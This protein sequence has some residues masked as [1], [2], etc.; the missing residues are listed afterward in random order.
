MKHS[1]F[2]SIVF[3]SAAMA[4]LPNTRAEESTTEIK[5]SDP[6]KPGTMRISLTRGEV[7][8]RG[9]DSPTITVKSDVKAPQS[10]PRKDGLR[11]IVGSSTFLLTEKDNVITLDATG[12]GARNSP[13]FNV[14]VPRSTSLVISDSLGGEIS[15]V[16]VNGDLEIKNMNGRI[17]LEGVAGGVLVETINGEVSADVRELHDGKPLSFTSMNGEITIRLP[18]DAK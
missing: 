3:F 18:A 5:F 2:S 7:R 14:T 8:I 15:C 4:V 12:D 10:K 17:K 1:V 11:E 13:N 16:D 9:N 6:T